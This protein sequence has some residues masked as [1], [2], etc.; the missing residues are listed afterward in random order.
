MLVPVSPLL[1]EEALDVG[2]QLPHAALRV[3]V[4]G[5]RGANRDPANADDIAEMARLA[6]EGI[7]VRTITPDELDEFVDPGQQS[8]MSDI[9]RGGHTPTMRLPRSA[10]QG[11]TSP[12][13]LI[14]R[15][16]APG[17]VAVDPHVAG[18]VVN[19]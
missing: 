6:A 19:P 16:V 15:D 5:D 8:R 12:A 7:E 3:Y 9:L 1:S 11:P 13:G 17:D 14:P 18:Q 2:A 10:D 4:M